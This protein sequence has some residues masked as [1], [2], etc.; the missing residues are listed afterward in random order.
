MIIDLF[1]IFP[2][3]A[4]CVLGFRDGIVKKGIGVVVTIIAL[5]VAQL[6]VNDVAEFYVNEFDSDRTDAVILGFYTVFFGL[7]FLQSLIYRL[8]GT[9]Y[10][11]GGIADRIIGS[12]LGLFQG[13][14][15][16]SVIF[17]MLNLTGFP[18]RSYRNDSRLYK[19]V[20]NIAPQI[21]D[22]TLEVVPEK[23]GEIKGQ[24]KERLDE[25]TKPDK[26][27]PK[28]KETP[29]QPQKR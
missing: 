5:I 21:L 23:T 4:L 3:I 1:I 13:L 25:F 11:I 14:V 16:M 20:V 2:V 15:I 29:S 26:P 8:S 9:E 6:M 18:S 12:I 10:R 7:V 17:M 22:F 28:Q 24:A 27:A 19:P